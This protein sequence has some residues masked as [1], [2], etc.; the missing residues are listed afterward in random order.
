MRALEVN[1]VGR[2]WS[3]VNHPGPNLI[4]GSRPRGMD[5]MIGTVIDAGTIDQ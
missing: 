1:A 3:F 4:I 5:P 2:A